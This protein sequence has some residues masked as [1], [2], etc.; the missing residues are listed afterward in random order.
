MTEEEMKQ[1]TDAASDAAKTATEAKRAEIIA[2]YEKTIDRKFTPG[3]GQDRTVVTKDEG[4]QP[5]TGGIGEQL[6]LIAKAYK[7]DMRQVDKKLLAVMAK[8][9]GAGEAVPSDG[10]FLVAQEFIPNIID[11]VYQTSIVAGMCAKQPVGPNFNGVKI[12]AVNET[13][14][15]DGYRWGGIL[16]YW[17]AEA[18]SITKSKPGIRQISVELQKLACLCYATDELLQ[19]SVG[20]TGYINKWFPMEMAFR[21]DDAVI[22]GDGAGKPLGIINSAN[23]ALI[24]ITK[25]TNQAATTIVTSN[26]LK[27][28]RRL[29]AANRPRAVWFYN[30]DCEEQLATLSVPIGTAGQ[31]F[32]LFAWPGSPTNPS[33]QPRIMGRPAYAIEQCPTLGAQGDIVLCDPT[34]Y[35]IIDKGGMQMATSI[36]VQFVTDET[37]FRFIY[38]VNGQPIWNSPLT[39]FKGSNTLSPYI[40]TAIRS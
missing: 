29:W 5:F 8:A 22:N 32:P 4:D 35:L 26:I 14:R 28:W 1:V 38:R 19:D 11:K 7:S 30:Q 9:T 31:L 16:G 24:A 18:G 17:M 2:E 13:S 40:V 12:P 10:G 36:H 15:L 25:E 39:P 6:G 3:A 33:E 21:L 34:E 23:P 20:L 37:A 27:M